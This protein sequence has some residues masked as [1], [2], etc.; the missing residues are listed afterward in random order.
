M[1]GVDLPVCAVCRKMGMA[2]DSTEAWIV[3][4]SVDEALRN[5]VKRATTE[6]LLKARKH[7][8][9]AFDVRRSLANGIERRLRKLERER[10]AK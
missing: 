7:M 2:Y 3:H 9:L 5:Q 6:E 10:K 8:Q 1:I 4:T